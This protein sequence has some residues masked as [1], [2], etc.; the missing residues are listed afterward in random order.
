[1]INDLLFLNSIKVL[2]L[3]KVFF[4]KIV[5]R[6]VR[7]PSNFDRGKVSSNKCNKML[8]NGKQKRNISLKYFVLM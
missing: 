6:S 2:Y 7:T 1:M 4:L 8:D 5:N 3:N